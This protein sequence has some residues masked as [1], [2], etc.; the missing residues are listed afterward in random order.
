MEHSLKISFAI[1][2]DDE[3]PKDVRSFVLRSTGQPPVFVGA[4][5]GDSERKASLAC[6]A[7]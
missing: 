5:K 2:G 7:G 3:G 4:D 1:E 6:S